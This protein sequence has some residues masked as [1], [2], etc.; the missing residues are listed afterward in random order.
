MNLGRRSC[1]TDLPLASHEAGVLARAINK[2]ESFHMSGGNLSQGQL[3]AILTQSLVKTKLKTLDLGLIQ[4]FGLEGLE[5]D[6]VARAK[7]VIQKL[8][9]KTRLVPQD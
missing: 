9:V 1:S 2:L 5:E 3:K 6:L 7:L 8:H 4:E